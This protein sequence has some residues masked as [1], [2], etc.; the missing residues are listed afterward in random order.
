[1]NFLVQTYAGMV[2]IDMHLD[3]VLGTGK[4]ESEVFLDTRML[5]ATVLYVCYFS[6]ILFS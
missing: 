4:G 6:N 2:K 3:I 1:M 5:V